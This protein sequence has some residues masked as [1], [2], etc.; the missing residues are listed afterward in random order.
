MKLMKT[1]MGATAALAMSAVGALADGPAII[2][3]LG[4][5]FDRSFNEA[6]FNGAER[7]AEATGGTYREIE[8]QSDAQREQA[9]RRLA[10]AGSNPIVM[11][12]FSQATPLP[13]SRP[14]TPTPPS[15]SSTAWSMNPTCARSSSPSM[16]APTS[17]A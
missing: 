17:W 11:A 14:T 8:L 13:L 7:W 5:K 10:E 15:S 4:G 16:R 12:G 6:A 3:D 2:F 1:L 9:M